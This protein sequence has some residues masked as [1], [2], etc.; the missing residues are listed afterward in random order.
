MDKQATNCRYFNCVA[1]EQ[2]YLSIIQL[3]PCVKRREIISTHVTRWLSAYGDLLP[4]FHS[5]SVVV[6]GR[7]SG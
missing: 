6:E 7:L 1:T 2:R 5:A 3:A 4:D